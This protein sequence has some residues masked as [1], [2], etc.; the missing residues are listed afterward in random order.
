MMI[1]RPPMD[2]VLLDVAELMASRGTCSIQQNGAIVA[3]D[4]RILTSGYNGSPRGLP[5]CQ[6]PELTVAEARDPDRATCTIAVHAEA[7]AVA[8]AARHGVA[9]NGA[10][11]YVT[12]SPCVVCAQLAVNAGVAQVVARRAYRNL[13]GV[14]LLQRAGV[15]V[16]FWNSALR[17]AVTT[18]VTT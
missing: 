10:T 3:R 14:N 7:N 6:H 5:H 16:L 12:T 18:P 4:G 8:F 2:E 1:D 13:T 17:A 11:L 9:L 15:V